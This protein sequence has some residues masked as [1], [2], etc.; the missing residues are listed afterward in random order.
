MIEIAGGIV[1]G[2]FALCAV[3]VILG[4]VIEH[5]AE[6]CAYLLGLIALGTTFSC[7][8]YWNLEVMAGWIILIGFGLLIGYNLVV[9][10]IE[11][12]R[13]VLLGFLKGI[14]FV[15]GYIGIGAVLVLSI[16]LTW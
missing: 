1:L 15:I 14:Y 9:A 5:I 8:L 11:N 13:K 6:I 3:L 16:V 4:F 10:L 2:F 12:P 7:V